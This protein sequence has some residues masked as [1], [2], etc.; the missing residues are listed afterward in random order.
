MFLF[1][2]TSNKTWLDQEIGVCSHPVFFGLQTSLQQITGKKKDMD[3][4]LDL[5]SGKLDLTWF[6]HQ[7][8][9]VGFIKTI[10]VRGLGS[11]GSKTWCWAWGS[12]QLSIVA[13]LHLSRVNKVKSHD[14]SMVLVY[15]YTNINGVYWWDPCYHIYISI[16][17][18]APWIRHGNDYFMIR[19]WMTFYL[20]E[21]SEGNQLP[22]LVR[23]RS[24]API[25]L[26][27]SM[28]HHWRWWGP[29]LP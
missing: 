23:W 25:L 24:F 27:L 7:N 26:N 13:C 8:L 3:L 21:T 2:S 22:V 10:G 5:N 20:L 14:G 6:N 15:I 19:P 4:Q 12:N 17:R 29:L 18:A 9:G 1:N 11:S 16:Y 28:A